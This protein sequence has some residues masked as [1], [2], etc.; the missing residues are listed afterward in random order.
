MNKV[1]LLSIVAAS[2]LLIG[3]GEEKASEA[4]K[5]AATAQEAKVAAK[6]GEGKCGGDK[7]SVATGMKEAASTAVEKTTQALKETSTAATQAASKAVESTKEVA[8]QAVEK[9]VEVAK[10]AKDA[11]VAK[12]GEAK[13]A[14]VAKVEEA[15]AAVSTPT[16]VNLAACAG[17]HGKDFEKKAMGV[18]RVVNTLTKAEIET[19]LKGYKDGTYGGNMKTLMK[20]QVGSFDDAK[21]KAIAEQVGK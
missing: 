4:P 7:K 3:C 8:T 2:V 11:V 18:S 17:C 21:I 13:E 19:A 1:T 5:A 16:T 15:K 14:V 10:E 6:C 12:A 20:G 9:T